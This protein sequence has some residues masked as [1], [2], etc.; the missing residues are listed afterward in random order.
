MIFWRDGRYVKS[1]VK[2]G[3]ADGIFT[4]LAVTD[5]IPLYLE[6]HLSR[7]R[8]SANALGLT[9]R[10]ADFAEI[11]NTLTSKN[12][13]RHA[14]CRITLGTGHMSVSLRAMPETKEAYRLSM[15]ADIRETPGRF[16]HKLA[17]RRAYEEMKAAAS[18]READDAL[19]ISA[20]GKILETTTAN[21][22][23]IKGA[24]ISTPPL[25]L[26]IL[27]GII[28]AIVLEK[29]QVTERIINRDELHAYESAF[30]TNSLKGIAPVAS[31]DAVAYDTAPALSLKKKLQL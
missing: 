27:P 29:A 28:R 19:I 15:T 6:R 1:E 10:E 20:D 13:M 7:L 26:P 2:T 17:D 30:I 5:G 12:G 22:F 8:S 24:D 18:S 14:A 31:I 16:R 4:T 11:I 3:L 21:I 25:S 23:F 9:S